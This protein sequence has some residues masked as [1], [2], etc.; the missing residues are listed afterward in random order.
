MN[1]NFYLDLIKSFKIISRETW[2]QIGKNKELIHMKK[3]LSLENLEF[4]NFLQ[5]IAKN[6]C[7]TLR[8]YPDS[9]VFYIIFQNNDTICCKISFCEIYHLNFRRACLMD[10]IYNLKMLHKKF[11]DNNNCWVS[12]FQQSIDLNTCETLWAEETSNILRNPMY[13]VKI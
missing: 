9:P 3:S 5:V 1:T 6:I 10:E 7:Y 4:G 13:N 12:V 11:Q 8:K 2:S